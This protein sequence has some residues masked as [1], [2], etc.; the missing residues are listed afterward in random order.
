MKFLWTFLVVIFAGWGCQTIVDNQQSAGSGKA[1][2]EIIGIYDSRAIAVGFIGSEIYSRTAGAEMKE[3]MAAYAA[4]K[5]TGDQLLMAELEAWGQ[6]Q[7]AVRH[8]QGFSTAP[9]DDILQYI[10]PDID[11]IISEKGLSGMT[12]KW[13]KSLKAQYLNAHLVDIT[14]ELL[15]ALSPN[16]KQRMSALE[17]MKSHPVPLENLQDID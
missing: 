11:R 3:K 6:A 9:I 5:E 17:I 13:D 14:I 2:K 1:T 15:D 8:R 16:D 7:Q 10:K 12:S 4:A